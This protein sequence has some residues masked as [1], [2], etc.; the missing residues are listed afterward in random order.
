MSTPPERVSSSAWV[1]S[2]FFSQTTRVLTL[3]R[4][5]ALGAIAL[6]VGVVPASLGGMTIST[7]GEQ[8][9]RLPGTLGLVGLVALG[10]LG[11]CLAGAMD[12]GGDA[13]VSLLAV[14]RRGV[15]AGA[16]IA[17][18]IMTVAPPALAIGGVDRL[19]RSWTDPGAGHS[20]APPAWAL[21]TGYLFAVVAFALVGMALSVILSNA[22]LAVS[23]LSLVPV[24]LLPRV[25]R[26]CPLLVRLLPYSACG[27][28][29]TGPGRVTAV[30]ELAGW[31]VVAAAFY[32]IRLLHGNG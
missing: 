10:C 4:T 32:T 9:H 15:L 16:R 8:P 6:L 19:I 23:I 5:R 2:V 30:L 22:V 27:A 13:A 17:S 31:A 24:L 20:P 1:R 12:R 26:W 7:G 21:L 29:L 14:P 3:P 28:A 25:G 11:G 18:L